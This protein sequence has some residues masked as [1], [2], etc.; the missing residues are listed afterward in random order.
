MSEDALNRALAALARA[1]Q[2]TSWCASSSGAPSATL[3]LAQIQQAEHAALEQLLADPSAPNAASLGELIADLAEITVELHRTVDDEDWTHV[4]DIHDVAA[5]L[6]TASSQAELME[7][8]GSE[9]RTLGFERVLLSQVDGDRWLPLVVNHGTLS[10]QAPNAECRL[11]ETK[12]NRNLA[13]FDLVHRRQAILISDAA[14]DPRVHAELQSATKTRSY[15][16]APVLVGGGVAGM[17]HADHLP[18][19]D[20]TEHDSALL[21]VF[22]AC[23]GYA[24]ERLSLAVRLQAVLREATVTPGAVL[25]STDQLLSLHS[26]PGRTGTAASRPPTGHAILTARELEVLGLLARGMSN[27][28]IAAEIVVSES[29]VKAHVKNILR[30]L[31]ATNRAEAVARFYR[32]DSQ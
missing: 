17:I 28:D 24:I 15:V 20:V 29:T 14:R 5:R 26:Q 7:L 25:T 1:H 18:H 12:I 21:G 23:L 9:L 22:A 27:S 30:K 6:R 3:L 11:G 16:A 8:A 2:R 10:E 13:E 4:V 32:G 19:R 31:G